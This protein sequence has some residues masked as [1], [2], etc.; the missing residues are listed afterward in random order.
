MARKKKKK[1]K[2]EP[3]QKQKQSQSIKNIINIT[4]KMDRARVPRKRNRPART[5]LA[6][7]TND[8]TPLMMSMMINRNQQP[9]PVQPAVAASLAMARQPLRE[10]GIQVPPQTSGVFTNPQPSATSWQAQRSPST[11]FP[12]RYESVEASNAYSPF[13]EHSITPQL[14]V[15]SGNVEIPVVDSSPHNIE[16]V[17]ESDVPPAPV[18]P[19]APAQV[20]PVQDNNSTFYQIK[21]NDDFQI[22]L[23]EI[24]IDENMSNKQVKKKLGELRKKLKLNI[25]NATKM[26]VRL[27][28]IATELHRRSEVP[29]ANTR[30]NNRRRR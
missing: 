1:K 21:D 9:P 7:P 24:D 17:V 29:A 20:E 25:P 11:S 18:E 14:E 19:I 8:L 10:Q 23:S 6:Y 15:Q 22:I 26:D 4:T 3:T 28:K 30:G 27:R 2:S 12:Q 16:P 13:Q 5:A